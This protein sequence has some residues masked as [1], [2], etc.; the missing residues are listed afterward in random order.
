MQ[1]E[2][3]F[4]ACS[5]KDFYFTTVCVASIRYWYPQIPIA[6]LTDLAWGP[7]DTSYLQTQWN[8]TLYPTAQKVFKDSFIKLEPLIAENYKSV[9]IMDADI[10]FLGRLLDQLEVIPT[11]FAAHALYLQEQDD[12]IEQWWFTLQALQQLDPAY[13]YPGF[14]FNAGFFVANASLFTK[15]KFETL[16]DFDGIPQL[17]GTI[18][19]KAGAEQGVL[20]YLVAKGVQQSKMIFTSCEWMITRYEP[21]AIKK[22][23]LSTIVNKKGYPSILHYNGPKNGIFSFLPAASIIKF[24]ERLYH[25]K[26]KYSFMSLWLT[27]SKRTVF[28]FSAF[29]MQCTKW[30]FKKLTF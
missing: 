17:K 6:L 29:L 3:I 24:Y 18:F 9:L 4:I 21:E 20:N 25:S 14:V 22:I 26:Q 13:R 15:Q 23:Q 5:K 19:S 27:R 30:V 10:I 11:D 28:H 7:I 2:K 12:T 16:I 1:I 8:V